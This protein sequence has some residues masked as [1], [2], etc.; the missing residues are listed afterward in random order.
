MTD[1]YSQSVSISMST[2]APAA[3]L[4]ATYQ[5]RPD[6]TCG[7]QPA[8]LDMLTYRDFCDLFAEERV[9]AVKSYLDRAALGE[10]VVTF[11]QL[12]C[13]EP[14]LLVVEADADSTGALLARVIQVDAISV[15]EHLTSRVLGMRAAVIHQIC[16]DLSAARLNSELAEK[17]L[18]AGNDTVDQRV[19]DALRSVIR[20]SKTVE[21]E[22]R[23]LQRNVKLNLQGSIDD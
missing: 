10:Q 1:P 16:N 2:T 8:L 19:V 23:E 6:E 20:L 13:G 22:L 5:L 4:V 15:P 21:A 14:R 12:A 18:Q 7:A 3:S 17:I 9:D 11:E